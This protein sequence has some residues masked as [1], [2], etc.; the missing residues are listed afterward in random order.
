[1]A[2][3]NAFNIDLLS[4]AWYLVVFVIAL[5]ALSRIFYKPILGMIE[6]RQKSINQA[7]DDAEAATASVKESQEKAQ[8]IL[9]DA[10]AEAQEIIRRAEKVGQDLQARAKEEAKEAAEQVK[11][12][13]VADIERE[14]LAAIQDVRRQAVDLALVA[15]SRVIEVNLTSEQNLK[16]AE[17]AIQQAEVGA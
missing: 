9:W 8:K 14:R 1:M 2:L 15:A 10:S 17:E 5:Y 6:E 7:L 4:L 3:F 16:L 11:A 13:A 12:K